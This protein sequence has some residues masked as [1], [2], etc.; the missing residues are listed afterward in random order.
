MRRQIEA[1][2]ES[3]DPD[4]LEYTETVRSI[5]FL[6]TKYGT[7]NAEII[8]AAFALGRDRCEVVALRVEQ[9]NAAQQAWLLQHERKRP[10]REKRAA[11]IAEK[12]WNRQSLLALAGPSVVYYIRR[13]DLVKIGVTT[14]L[15]QRMA[16]ILPDEVLAIEPGDYAHEQEMHE[17]FAELRLI[18][19]GSKEWFCMGPDLIAHMTQIRNDHGTPPPGLPVFPV[20]R[21][22]SSSS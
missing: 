17:R 14:N 12:R 9:K 7:L 6:V 21:S 5:V 18:A 2:G 1:A 22:T 16:A 8:R 4:S 19:P 20:Q 3:L 10:E 11:E 15:Y 13:G